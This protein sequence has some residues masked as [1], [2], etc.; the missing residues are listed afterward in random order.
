MFFPQKVMWYGYS[1]SAAPGMLDNLLVYREVK[2]ESVLPQTSNLSVAQ[3]VAH[4][5][6]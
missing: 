2:Y 3:H 4:T 1:V 5:G 6:S